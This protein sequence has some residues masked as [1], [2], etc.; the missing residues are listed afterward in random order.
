MGAAFNHIF[1][2]AGDDGE[3]GGDVDYFC[4]CCV[5]DSH[6]WRG[7]MVSAAPAWGLSWCGDARDGK[8]SEDCAVPLKYH[9]HKA[10]IITTT[11][12]IMKQS[13]SSK[14]Y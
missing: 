5:C 3:V 1:E 10:N 7:E 8:I 2:D 9:A 6:G 12:L 4:S 13:H 11:D 14:K